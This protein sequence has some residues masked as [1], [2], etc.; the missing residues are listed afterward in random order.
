MVS[1][2]GKIYCREAYAQAKMLDHSGW[3]G[4]LPRGITPSDIDM[5]IDNE[6]LVLFVEFSS[7]T[8]SWHTLKSKS[9]GQWK[10]HRNLVWNGRGTQFSAL[11]HLQPEPDKDI[12]SMTDVIEFSLML[13]DSKQDD[14]RESKVWTGDNWL[15]AVK[16]LLNIT[17]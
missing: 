8:A 7:K 13:Y 2:K 9:Y 14:V 11:C 5:V 12:N 16:N 1:M 10:L 3:N 4:V 6:G 15:A 17:T